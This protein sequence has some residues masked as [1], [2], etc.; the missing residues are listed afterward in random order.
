MQQLILDL[1]TGKVRQ[2][3]WQKWWIEAAMFFCIATL[4]RKFQEQSSRV[5]RLVLKL[6]Q[7]CEINVG[8][9]WAP[10]SLVFTNLINVAK[11]DDKSFTIL[12]RSTDSG[13]LIWIKKK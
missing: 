5:Q 7:F 6:F 1:N 12:D 3:K 10:I 4:F 8:R 9:A 2:R 13:D 11:E